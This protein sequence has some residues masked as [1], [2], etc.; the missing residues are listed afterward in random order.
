MFLALG[1]MAL[2]RETWS[3]RKMHEIAIGLTT[4]GGAEIALG[5]ATIDPDCDGISLRAS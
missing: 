5:T 4:A 2:A 3:E 1:R